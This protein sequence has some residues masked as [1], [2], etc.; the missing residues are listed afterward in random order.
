MDKGHIAEI[1]EIILNSI[2]EGV[3]TVDRQ[4]RITFFNLAAEK[5]TGIPRGNAIGRQC[6]EVFHASICKDDCALRQTIE[7]RIP[8][9]NKAITIV[10]AEGK[11]IPI[12]VS[13]GILRDNKNQI[14]GGVETFRD[15]SLV[16][17]LRKELKGRFTFADII[18]KNSHIQ[19]I[20]R[21]LPDVAESDSTVLIEGPTGSGKE[22][23]ARA[24]HD[25]SPRQE[26]PLVAVNC[27]ALPDPLLESELFGYVAGAFTDARRDKLGLFARAHRGTILLDEIGDISPALQVKLLRVL[28]EKEYEPLGS[29]TTVKADVRVVAA[30]NKNL[31]ELV[32]QGHFRRDLYYRVNVIKL[33]LPSLADRKEDIPLLVSHFIER[34]NNLRER[35]VEGISEEALAILMQH[36]FPGNVRELENIIEHA[37]V[38]CKKGLIFPRHLPV[39]LQGK[40]GD[41]LPLSSG[42]TLPEMEAR[43]I[44][45]ALDRNDWKRSITARELG[46]DKSTLWRKI[47]RLNEAGLIKVP[48]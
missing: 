1:N 28:Q 13:T 34:F 10:N 44:L 38:L 12:S 18:S 48:D 20:F 11:K 26:S 7:K 5:V 31:D 2:T 45:E 23:F 27:A 16:E 6:W 22:L 47:K 43:M 8:V 35:N 46:I 40:I 24:I 17:E 42:C 21:I 25:L 37:F 14:I 19:Q 4:W 36:N 30:T 33:T 32:G 15:L 29:T 9:L 41:A 39:S 3:F